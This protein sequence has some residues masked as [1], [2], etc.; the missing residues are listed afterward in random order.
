MTTRLE[1][2]RSF[3]QWVEVGKLGP[4]PYVIKSSISRI[5]TRY[6]VVQG[7]DNIEAV[8]L[9]LPPAKDDLTKKLTSAL[10]KPIFDMEAA[11][12]LESGH[13]V[14]IEGVLPGN[15]KSE[16]LRLTQE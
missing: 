1:V 11:E 8:L 5:S 16:T 14:F 7:E 4:E 12:L 10:G 15:T 2:L 3:G 13:A 9:T 6:V